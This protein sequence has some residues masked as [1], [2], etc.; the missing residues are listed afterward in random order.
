MIKNLLILFYRTYL[1]NIVYVFPTFAAKTAMKL[2]T[3]PRAGK[4]NKEQKDFLSSATKQP[5]QHKE[6]NLNSYLWPG[7]EKTILLV[8]GWESNSGRWEETILKLKETGYSIVAFDGPAHGQSTGARF[9][10]ILYAECIK[11]VVD[12]YKPNVIIGH[13]VGGMSAIYAYYKYQFA[14]LEKIVS[15]AAPS[16][17]THLM[18]NYQNIIGFNDKMMQAIY[19]YVRQQYNFNPYEFSAANFAASFEL[20]TLIIHDKYDD[21]I[22]Y[23]EGVAIANSI[24]NAQFIATEHLGHSVNTIEVAKYIYDFVKG[25]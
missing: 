24:T 10:G 22:A 23:E 2:Y 5:I 9:D 18:D 14:G 15:I 8:H 21:V 16:E 19:S 12:F 25:A 20:D 6:L 1:N 3:T 7:R 4:L 13:S 17:F 11:T